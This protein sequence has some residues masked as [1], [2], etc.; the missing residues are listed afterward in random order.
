LSSGSRYCA[1][2]PKH[3]NKTVDYWIELTDSVGNVTTG[4]AYSYDQEG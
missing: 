2:I 1:T 4:S 3:N